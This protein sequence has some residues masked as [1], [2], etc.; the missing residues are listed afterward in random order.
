[1]YTPG[2]S[3]STIGID[4]PIDK[5]VLTVNVALILFCFSYN[6]IFSQDLKTTEI[7][8]VE[9]LDVSVPDAN[10]LNVKAFFM[11]TTKI[12]KTQK[13]SFVDKAMYSS[14][15]T[16]PL[17]AARI[18]NKNQINTNSTNISLAFGNNSYQSGKFNFTKIALPA[19]LLIPVCSL[20]IFVTKRS[21]PTNCNF[22]PIFFVNSIQPSQS[23][24][25]I[26][27]SIE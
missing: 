6:Y 2:R 9:G 7:R 3:V 18:K 16:R 13:Y 24:S 19:F 15:N 17:T 23:S 20:L 21:S 22:V 14:F 26:P 12:D 1:M 8:V 5:L 4:E 11:D 10:K 25:D 27:S